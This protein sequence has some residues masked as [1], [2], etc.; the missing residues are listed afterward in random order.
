M[1]NVSRSVLAIATIGFALSLSGCCVTS[2]TCRKPICQSPSPGYAPAPVYSESY[3]PIPQGIQPADTP[4]I[5]PTPAQQ[6]VPPAPIP[7]PAPAPVPQSTKRSFGNKTAL[8]F[9]SMNDRVKGAF[10]RM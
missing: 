9:H 8:M 10:Q 5:E 7:E 2:L 3:A 1:T 4:P 6:Y